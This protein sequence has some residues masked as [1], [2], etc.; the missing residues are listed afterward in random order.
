MYLLYEKLCA[1][2]L[3]VTLGSGKKSAYCVDCYA[4][5]GSIL[6]WWTVHYIYTEYTTATAPVYIEIVMIWY[7]MKMITHQ[8]FHRFKTFWAPG[9]NCPGP[10][11]P[12]FQS[13]QSG[14]RAQ[15]S[16]FSRKTV[17]LRGPTIHFFKP[18]SWAPVQSINQSIPKC[19]SKRQLTK[20]VV[21][22]RNQKK[23][24]DELHK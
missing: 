3:D 21:L 15:V 2:I 9:P 13:E 23:K 12:L 11:C 17:G 5:P 22:Y 24:K 16:T 20:S 14:P 6:S 7:D 1:F 10:D 8:S 18:D 19:S 4:A